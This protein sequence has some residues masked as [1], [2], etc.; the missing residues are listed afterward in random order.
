MLEREHP[1]LQKFDLLIKGP[2]WEKYVGP[3]YD[4]PPVVTAEGAQTLLLL[5]GKGRTLKAAAERGLSLAA[6]TEYLRA[7]EPEVWVQGDV[8][9]I[10]S[11]TSKEARASGRGVLLFCRAEV[12]EEVIGSAAYGRTFT[13]INH[14]VQIDYDDGVPHSISGMWSTDCGHASVHNK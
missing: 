7:Y 9:H 4:R 6:V 3:F 12:N 8:D 1:S 10:F 5:L 14:Y 2:S 13:R 11:L